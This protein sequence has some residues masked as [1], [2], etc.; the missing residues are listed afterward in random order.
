MARMQTN[1]PAAT[2]AEH[3]LRTPLAPLCY[4]VGSALGLLFATVVLLKVPLIG[5]ARSVR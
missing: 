4:S 2:Q 1:S 5:L 3:F